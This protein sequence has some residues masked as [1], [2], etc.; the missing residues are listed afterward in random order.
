MKKCLLAASALVCGMA[1]ALESANVVGYQNAKITAGEW[2]LQGATFE[3]VDSSKALT[4]GDIGANDSFE[5]GSDT[6]QTLTGTGGTKA[7]YTYC[8]E[9]IAEEFGLVAGW[10]DYTEVSN[11]DGETTLTLCNNVELP[12]GSMAIIQAGSSDA[13]LIYAGAVKA[14]DAVLS[15]DAG[16]WNMRANCMPVDYTLGDLTANEFFEF[17][18]D[19]LQTLTGT[20]GTKA[21][22]T[23]CSA[24]IA[25]EFGLEPGWYD[26]TEVSNWDGETAL[27][28]C[29]SVDIPAGYGF[30]L[31]AGSDEATVIV[32]TPL[33]RD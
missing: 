21:Q 25:E 16:V 15:I 9:A 27:T 1:M 23:Y 12:F 17:G 30:I 13:A 32:P 19:T 2:N 24:A 33:P 5:F 10:Y 8:S 18:S 31:Q 20:G 29:N 28:L 26:Y 4:L 7:Q 22:Y 3:N 6:L 11:W 14:E